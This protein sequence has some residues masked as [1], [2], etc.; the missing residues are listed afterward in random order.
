MLAVAS[1]I[2]EL[3]VALRC[4]C[5]AVVAVGLRERW[6]LSSVGKEV[7]KWGNNRGNGRPLVLGEPR[8]GGVRDSENQQLGWSVAGGKEAKRPRAGG[9]SPAWFC[10]MGMEREIR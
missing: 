1:A 2:L 6:L 7:E 5:G 10:F 8:D 3:T 9:W 4:C